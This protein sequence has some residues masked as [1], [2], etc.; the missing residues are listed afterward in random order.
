MKHDAQLSASLDYRIDIEKKR[1]GSRQKEGQETKGYTPQ[2]TLCAT[3]ER[4]KKKSY[5]DDGMVHC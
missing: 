2:N 3:T 5:Q 1:P 4:E